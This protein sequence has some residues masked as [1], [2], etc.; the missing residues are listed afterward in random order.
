MP[1]NPSIYLT[2]IL[3]SDN[4]ITL[5]DTIFALSFFF[6]FQ[7]WPVTF[8]HKSREKKYNGVKLVNRWVNSI[9]L[10]VANRWSVEEFFGSCDR[11]ASPRRGFQSIEQRFRWPRTAPLKSPHMSSLK[12]CTRTRA[13]QKKKKKKK[14]K[15]ERR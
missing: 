3:T 6:F 14:R 15:K 7:T 1:L 4:A 8:E 10:C 5:S 11:N 12:A 9:Q 2:R 13:L